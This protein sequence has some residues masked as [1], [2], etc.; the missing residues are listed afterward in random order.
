MQVQPQVQIQLPPISITSTVID[1][2]TIKCAVENYI[3]I[4]CIS[5]IDS[6]YITNTKMTHFISFKLVKMNDHLRQF[7]LDLEGCIAIKYNHHVFIAVS[8]LYD[9]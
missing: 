6:V 9:V 2:N 8:N 5:Y 1:T 4:N 7:I 3:G